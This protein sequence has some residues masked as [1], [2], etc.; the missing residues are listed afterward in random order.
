[1]P[2]WMNSKKATGGRGSLGERR[3][4][5]R[6]DYGEYSESKKAEGSATQAIIWLIVDNDNDKGTCN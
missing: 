4:V 6:Q 5:K 3:R 1:M 2:H